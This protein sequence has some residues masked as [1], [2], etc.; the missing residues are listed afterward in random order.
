MSF[1]PSCGVEARE[2]KAFCYNCGEPMSQS[3]AG[4]G[5]K[6]SPELFE[7]TAGAPPPPYARPSQRPE[8]AAPP[9][10]RRPDAGMS[11]G[12]G[13]GRKARRKFFYGKFGLGV[14]ALLLLILLGFFALAVLVN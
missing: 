5:G 8:E 1:C 14:V 4:R 6:P 9:E 11:R 7:A 2:G 13:A 3:A 10:L 12:A